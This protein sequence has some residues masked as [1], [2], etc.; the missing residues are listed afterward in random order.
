VLYETFAEAAPC[1]VAMR[2]KLDL[3]K[4]IIGDSLIIALG[5][6]FV[7]H[8]IMF[9]VYGRLSI[10]EPNLWVRG[11]ETALFFLVLCFGI[12]RFVWHIRSFVP[13][14]Y[15]PGSARSSARMRVVAVPVT[16]KKSLVILRLVQSAPL[17]VV[18]GV[19]RSRGI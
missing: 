5:G 3:L 19:S 16:G 6:I 11:F 17:S 13:I 9:W 10:G 12:E 8:F 4:E 15:R 1:Q 7:F 14:R 18:P 2:R